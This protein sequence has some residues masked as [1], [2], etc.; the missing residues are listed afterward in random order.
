M[1]KLNNAN[2]L[3]KDLICNVINLADQR[4][5]ERRQHIKKYFGEA[6]LNFVFFPAYNKDKVV[7]KNK[8]LTTGEVA[9]SMSHNELY[10]KLLR[11]NEEYMLIAEDDCTIRPNFKYYLNIVLN[12]LPLDFDVIKLEYIKRYKLFGGHNM[13]DNDEVPNDY[14]QELFYDKN[15]YPGTAMYLISRKGAKY[16]LELNDPVWIA[17]DWAFDKKWQKN[18]KLANVYNVVP[19]IAWQGEVKRII[20]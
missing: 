13:E 14:S 17:S 6:H 4:G 12:N 7:N 3:K 18:T 8:I 9:L 11:S 10:K 1:I 2:I 16:M 15:V 20:L 19:Q 5:E